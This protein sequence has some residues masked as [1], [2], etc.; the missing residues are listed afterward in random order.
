MRRADPVAPFRQA[1]GESVRGDPWLLAE[2]EERVGERAEHWDPDLTLRLNR[3]VVVDV[4]AVLASTGIVSADQLAIAAV[5]KSDRTRLRG[6]GM[7]V[8]LGGRNGEVRLSLSLDVPGYLAGGT[9]EIRTVL[10]RTEGDG[11]ESP[12]V[13]RRA[14]A[15]LWSERVSVALEGS[16]ARFPVTV[17]DFWEVP[18]LAGDA[19]WALEWSPRDLDQPVLGAMRLL[20]NSGLPRVVQAISGSDDA[21]GRLITS[22]MRFDTAR[23][24]VHGALSEE[25]F[26]QGTRE[27]EADSVG[28]M[29]TNLLDRYWPGIAPEVLARRLVETPHRLESDLQVRTGLLA[30]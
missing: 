8:P 25:E 11:K 4:N 5:W 26:V 23:S 16:A 2:S 19:P 9:L 7:S 18:G 3:T 27:F 30:E 29:L 28:R 15:V 20:V 21:E 13:A 12:T 10:I 14:G 6:P 17:L 1:A 22:M 24:L